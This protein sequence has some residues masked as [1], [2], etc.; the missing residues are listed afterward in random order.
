M[1]AGVSRARLNVLAV[2]VCD[3]A[4]EHNSLSLFIAAALDDACRR[5]GKSPTSITDFS[6]STLPST[7]QVC[8]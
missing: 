4:A 5:C 8:R 2:E 6:W 3:S 1:V 7:L